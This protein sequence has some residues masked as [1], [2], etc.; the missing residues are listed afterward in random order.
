MVTGNE[1]P[2]GALLVLPGI[3]VR[4]FEA[5]HHISG[6]ARVLI[7]AGWVLSKAAIWGC[8]CRM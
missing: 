5:C 4:K 2:Q 1:I 6:Y 7:G 8:C 3:L